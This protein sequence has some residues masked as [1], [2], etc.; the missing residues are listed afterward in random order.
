[1]LMRLMRCV[2]AVALLSSVTAAAGAVAPFDFDTTPGRLPKTVVPTDYQIAIVPNVKARKLAGTETVTLRV[3]HATDRIT[4]NTLGMTLHDVRLDGVSVARVNTENAKQLTT[5]TLARPV[6]AG[7]HRL[8]LAYDGTI[9]DSPAGLFAQDY[10]KPDGSI[11]TMLSTQFESTDARRMFP[12]W[13]EPAFRATFALSVTVPATWNTI[14][15]TPIV[16]RTV[17]G[18]LATTTFARTPRMPT[19]L[20][21]LAAGELN[22]IG[23][24][25]PDGV[26]QN[27]WAVNGD[28]VNGR[29]TLASAIQILGY[30]D[31]YFGVRFPLPKLDHIAIPGGFG[32]AME[33]WGGITYNE[34]LIIHRP[35]ATLAQKQDGYSV[36]AHEMAHQWNG[37]LVTMGWWDD[38]WLNESFASWMAAKATNRF[39]PGWQWW[40]GEDE[41]K[42]HAMDADALTT[43]HAIQ[44]HVTDELQADASFDPEIT[45]DKGQAFLRMLEAYVGE[46]TFR[47]GIRAYMKKHAYS[48][49]TTA[50]LWNALGT[51]SRKDVGAFAKTWTEQPGF[52]VVSVTATCDASGNRTIALAQKRF[53]L[54]GTDAAN[55]RWNV[56]I[57]LAA[58]AAGQPA[59]VLLT[60]PEQSGIPAGKCGEPLRANA[61]DIGY[62]RVAYDAPTLEANRKAFATLPSDDKIVM[63][64]DQWALVRAGNAQLSS[65]LALAN[66]MGGDR[67]ARAWKQIAGALST[68][69]HDARGTAQHDAVAAYARN[70]VAP[71]ATA[72]GWDAKPNETASTGNL[73]RALLAALGQWG[74][75]ATVAEARRRFDDA[76]VRSTLSPDVQEL[77]LGI[78][79]VSA[80]VATFD[81]LHALALAAKDPTLAERYRGALMGVRDPALAAR[82]LAIAISPEIPPQLESRRA[83]L[84][85]R[86][87]DWNPALAWSFYQAHADVLTQRFSMFEKILNLATGLPRTYSDAAPLEQIDAWLEGYLP[88]AAAPYIARGIDRAHTAVAIK[89]RLNTEM[90]AVVGSG[91]RAGG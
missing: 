87:A 34:S 19:Y 40:Q 14:S 46:D 62:Y 20:V 76:A 78:V 55:P 86:V 36:V 57:E 33:N 13:D 9:T 52:P 91:S 26:K 53:L 4:F 35:T 10:R 59:L 60:K 84:I 45:Y 25:G 64:D 47:A 72:L 43:S 28:E 42:E 30:Y 69:E 41:T 63:L 27:V 77:V 7:M 12:A 5:L 23:G 61:G 37:D 73:R 24:V 16:A 90:T 79:A 65:Y 67:N 56:P 80:D 18:T 22:A 38:I 68:L 49:A 1:M 81:R 8:T 15:N 39:N 29:Y 11:G 83:R 51:A 54:A 48:N 44:Q 6:P 75:P 32:G 88:P 66:A 50:D 3:R 21:V 58:G 31:E 82:A 17:R 71:V 85:A 70:L 89:S 2:F 74:D